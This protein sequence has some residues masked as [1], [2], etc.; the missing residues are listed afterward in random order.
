MTKEEPAESTKDDLLDEMEN[1]QAA[2]DNWAGRQLIRDIARKNGLKD[3]IAEEYKNGVRAS[4]A[5]PMPADVPRFIQLTW[6]SLET[7]AGTSEPVRVRRHTVD[8]RR[9]DELRDRVGGGTEI[10]TRE[11]GQLLAM[12]TMDTIMERIREVTEKDGGRCFVSSYET[13]S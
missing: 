9:I 11:G 4:M 1:L 13:P 2:M 8:L 10:Y 5:A 7:K 6:R 12:E 3:V